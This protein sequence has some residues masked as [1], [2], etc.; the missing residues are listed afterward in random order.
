MDS[1][2]SR[3]WF[4]VD[5]LSV[6]LR[7]K[8][9]IGIFEN[10]FYR[11][12]LADSLLCVSCFSGNVLLFLR[13]KSCGLSRYSIKAGNMR[14]YYSRLAYPNEHFVRLFREFKTLW[15]NYLYQSFL[16]TLAV[17]IVLWLLSAE[18]AVIIASIGATAFIVFT[19]PTYVT[20]QSRRVIGG[21]C[22]GFLC[23]TL[24][25]IILHNWGIP[26]ILVY[27]LTVGLSIFLM[28]ALDFEHPPASGTAL[29]VVVSGFSFKVLLAIVTSALML[30]LAHHYMKK[31]LKDLI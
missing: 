27:S 8:I 13:P 17:L 9:R 28:V 4:P 23:G 22:T 11:N 3:T 16:A 2:L 25:A 21:H 20:A 12:F 24:G 7:V 18:E 1:R 14:Q 30:S 10:L 31:Y 19:M 26:V 29:G 5:T 15:K 6:V